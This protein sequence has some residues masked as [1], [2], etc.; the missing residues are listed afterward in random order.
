MRKL[1]RGAVPA[2][3]CLASFKHGQHNWD[4][5]KGPHKDQIRQHLEQMQGR[6]CA[7][8]EGS[9]DSLGQHVD[10]FQQKDKVPQ[11]TFAWTNL[12]WSCYQDDSCG[13]IKDRQAYQPQDLIDPCLDDP[14]RYFLFRSDGS[15]DLRQGLSPADQKRARETLRILNL[16]PRS[17]RLRQMRQRAVE[18][19]LMDLEECIQAG[20]PPAQYFAEVLAAAIHLPFFTTVRHVLTQP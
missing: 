4:D 16:D 17:G 14:D 15:I 13:R 20:L 1:D 12:L 6:F 5:V 2:P 19:F 9:L 18:G 7:Y 8:C 3:P 10:H 11:L